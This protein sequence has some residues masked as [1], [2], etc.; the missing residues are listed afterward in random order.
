MTEKIRKDSNPV[1]RKQIKLPYLDNPEEKLSFI[2]L[3]MDSADNKD[4]DEGVFF[5]TVG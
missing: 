5:C 2:L 1:F 3:N 4:G